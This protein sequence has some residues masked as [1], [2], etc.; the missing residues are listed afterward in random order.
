M[1]DYHKLHVWSRAHRL[2][3]DVC[4]HTRSFPKDER[5]GLV[6]QIR[7]AASSAPMN[8]A[9]GTGRPTVSDFSRFLGIAAGS[10]QELRYQLELA[11]DLG[12][13]DPR[14]SEAMGR[15]AAELR[16]MIAGLRAKLGER[17]VVAPEHPAGDTASGPGKGRS[18]SS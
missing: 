13:G 17:R 16:A 15:E 8:I 10:L 3:L 2:A 1:R 9:E 5:F 6:A 18:E 11:R 14:E 4:H 12:Y 7:R